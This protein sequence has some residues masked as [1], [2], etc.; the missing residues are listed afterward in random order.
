MGLYSR[1]KRRWKTL[2]R[3]DAHELVWQLKS[4]LRSVKMENANFD[5]MSSGID[6]LENKTEFIKQETRIYRKS[7]QIEPLEKI[8]SQLSNQYDL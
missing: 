8:I 5:G 2:G 6:A 1:T 3:K 4:V 7:W